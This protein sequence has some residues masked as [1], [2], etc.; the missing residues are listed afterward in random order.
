MTFWRK[1]AKPQEDQAQ[2]ASLEKHPREPI[3]PAPNPSTR[4]QVFPLA[5]NSADAPSEI[6]T[7][8]PDRKGL[9]AKIK[10]GQNSRGMLMTFG[11]IVA[12]LMR[13]PQFRTMPLSYLES[14]VVPGILTGQYLVA[15]AKSDQSGLIAP[16]AVLLWASVSEETERKILAHSE[17]PI[18]LSAP[19]WRDGSIP[20][21]VAL[22]G[23]KRFVPTLLGKLHEALGGRQIKTRVRTP[24]G[25][26]EVQM[27]TAKTP[28]IAARA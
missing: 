1:A 8:S 12:V 11:E 21:L 20:W 6:G 25:K 13:S 19:E 15:E 28:E 23:D 22:A 17:T 5:T 7:L 27:L 2:A 4:P 18:M 14:L 3:A 24:D 16:V 10:V 26:L 9:A